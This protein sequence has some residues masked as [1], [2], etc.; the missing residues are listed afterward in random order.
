MRENILKTNN[1]LKKYFLKQKILPILTIEEL[2]TC[3]YLEDIFLENGVRTFEITLRT[4][5]ALKAISIMSSNKNF[6]V[7]AGTLKNEKDVCSAMS[8]GAK[9]G[10]SPGISDN[11]FNE[12]E[13][14]SFP[15]IPGVSS[16]SEIMIAYN[17]GYEILKLF[18]VEVIGGIK[19]LIALAGPFPDCLFFP[20]GGISQDN[21]KDYL[22]L[23]NVYGVAGSWMVPKNL[24]DQSDWNAIRKILKSSLK[25]NA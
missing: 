18:P 17:R 22:N 25:N 20:T 8:A 21:A 6:I 13:R 16:P 19:M 5:V 2:S 15:L 1:V 7:G 3:K 11:L 4:E 24:V 23:S 10:V 14:K 12:C 9:F